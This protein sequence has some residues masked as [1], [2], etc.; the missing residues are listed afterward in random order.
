MLCGSGVER[1]PCRAFVAAGRRPDYTNEQ[2]C[3]LLWSS[4][5]GPYGSPGRSAQLSG[6]DATV[7]YAKSCPAAVAS[8]PDYSGAPGRSGGPTR[9]RYRTPRPDHRSWG[10]AVSVRYCGPAGHLSQPEPDSSPRRRGDEKG[11]PC[12]S[13]SSVPAWTGTPTGVVIENP[14]LPAPPF[15]LRRSPPGSWRPS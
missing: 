7:G 8:G 3:Y 9:R 1:R 10:E 13:L 5:V 12:P 2:G 11:H 6:D 15:G 14:V 4:D